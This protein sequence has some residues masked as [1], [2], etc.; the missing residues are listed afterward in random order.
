VVSIVYPAVTATEFHRSLAAGGMV[1]GGSRSVKPH[2]AEFVAEA[3]LGLIASG[4][5]EV[6]LTQ[7]WG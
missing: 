4:E 7:G 1:G 5:E 2:T 3:I 6:Q